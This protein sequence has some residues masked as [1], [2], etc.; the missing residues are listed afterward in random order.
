M[1]P[2]CIRKSTDLVTSRQATCAGFLAQA[3]AKG[4]KAAPF[5]KE[6]AEL[7]SALQQSK[8]IH[9]LV[10]SVS[11][12]QL[13]TAVGFS[14]KA[15]RYFSDEELRQAINTELEAIAKRCGESFREE[16]LYRF[17]L[18]RGDTLGGEMRNV[19]GALA[20]D[21][22][23]KGLLRALAAKGT[24]A[25]SEEVRGKITRISFD[26]RLLLLDRTPQ[27]VGKNIDVILLKM[28]PMTTPARELVEDRSLYLACGEL[29]GGID[30]AGADEHWKT[31]RSALDRIREQFPMNCP[32]LF[33]VAAAI[34][35]A[36]AREI[37]KQLK[38]DKLT[39]AANA[40]VAAQV[41]E[42]IA[43]L[44]AL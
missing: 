7:W 1:L 4:Q 6:A 22:I 40:T 27:I 10:S 19:T 44:L 8:D 20:Q 41:D 5:V 17:L 18:T 2:K 26:A 14:D 25:Q 42:L 21:K 34:E 11:L 3:R 38:A 28:P 43:W 23:I 31:A 35:E 39:F 13:A 30:P 29:K 16:I 12:E 32:K 33:F 9:A 37:Y 24:E 36:M 15:Q